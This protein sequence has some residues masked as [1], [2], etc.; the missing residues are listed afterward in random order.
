MKR[1]LEPEL[2]EDDEQAR[3]Y[4]AAD[5]EDAHAGFVAH[6]REVFPNFD[7]DRYVLDLGCGPGDISIR[8]ARA[9]PSCTVHGVDG[10]DAMLRYGQSRLDADADVRER[11]LLINGMLPGAA[12]PRAK[13]D[14]VI[15]NSLLH[16]LPDPDALWS[17]VR[18]H[19]TK[20]HPIFVMDLCRPESTEQANDLV[21]QYAT[22][23][24][25]VLRKDFYNSLLAAFELDEVVEQIAKADLRNLSVER[26]TDRHLIVHG[27]AP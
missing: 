9:Y 4:A 7:T 23:E 26:I 16:H 15:S 2:M 17:T 8:F 20:D 6:F 3:A 24:P 12:L 21:N 5:F 18:A 1:I 10:S 25:E 27:L 22:G 19:A 13:Y 11:V 14:A